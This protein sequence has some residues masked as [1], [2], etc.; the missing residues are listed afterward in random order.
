MKKFFTSMTL[1]FVAFVLINGTALGEE[2]EPKPSKYQKKNPF[3]SIAKK[4]KKEE[5]KMEKAAA[6][7]KDTE[8][9]TKKIEGLNKQ[10]KAQNK[11]LVDSIDKKRLKCVKKVDNAKDDAD[12]SKNQATIDAYDED[13]RCIESWFEDKNPAGD[14]D[15]EKKDDDKKKKKH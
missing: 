11:K 8:K 12:T 3:A 10:K 14:A 9:Y 15:E 5:A 6:K 1:F 13:I 7:D 4:I 2:K